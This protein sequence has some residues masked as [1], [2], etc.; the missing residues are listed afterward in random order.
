[1]LIAQSNVCSVRLCSVRLELMFYRN[2]VLHAEREVGERETKGEILQR[3]CEPGQAC[4][5]AFPPPPSQ[6][7]QIREVAWPLPPPPP[8]P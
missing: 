8:L 5:P 4:S 1:M 3:M 2:R 6:I 7:K